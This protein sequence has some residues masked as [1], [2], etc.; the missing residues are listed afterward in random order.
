LKGKNVGV[1][2]VEINIGLEMA[3]VLNHAC[4]DSSRD[5]SVVLYKSRDYNIYKA[6]FE[7]PTAEECPGGHFIAYSPLIE[8]RNNVM[9]YRY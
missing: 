5:E 4:V 3:K 2:F 1:L 9:L 6:T 8:Q 7:R